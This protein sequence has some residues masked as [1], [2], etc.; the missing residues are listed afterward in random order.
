MLGD[1][2]EDLSVLPSY[3]QS[4]F[5]LVGIASFTV[6]VYLLIVIP[7]VFRRVAVTLLEKSIYALVVL[8]LLYF[9]V[10]FSLDPRFGG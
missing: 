1:I 7:R 2:R 8:L 4:I 10:A 6:E 3:I 5:Y 9:L